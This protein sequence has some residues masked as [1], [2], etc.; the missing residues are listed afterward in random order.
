[1]PS[2]RVDVHL[3][4]GGDFHD[5]DFA[6][7]RLLELL[8]EHERIRATVA[9]D[10]SSL[11]D[12][13]DALVTYTCNVRPSEAQQERLADWVANGGRWFALHGTNSALDLGRPVRSPRAFPLY[14]RVLGSQ[15]VAH[16]VI[17]PYTVSVTDA[18]HP[19]CA[20]VEPFEVT[21][22]LYLSELHDPDDHHLLLHTRWTGEAAGFEESAWPDDDLRPVA[23]LRP[24]H[25]GEVLYLTL[26]HCRGH[27]DMQPH[28][29]WYPEVE[30]GSWELPVF[31]ELLRR[32]IRWLL[33]DL[34]V[35]A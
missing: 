3:V 1:M 7:L 35:P 2:P 13:F 5:F 28:V 12:G 15:F 10:F 20:G 25:D 17:A 21:D 6:R 34:Y 4:V 22:E 23:Y 11:P 18:S 24:W 30:R 31:A 16:P 32:G 9:P 26:G 29:E 8:G 33:E 14:A 27:Y 19:F